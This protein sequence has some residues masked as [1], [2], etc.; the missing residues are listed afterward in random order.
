MKASTGRR[1]SALSVSLGKVLS[2]LASHTIGNRYNSCAKGK[3]PTPAF[4]FVSL[5][6]WHWL[7]ET[8]YTWCTCVEPFSA[9]W[10]LHTPTVPTPQ[11]PVV[12]RKT[13]TTPHASLSTRNMPYARGIAG[14]SL[15]FWSL[16]TNVPARWLGTPRSYQR[17]SHL[18]PLSP[19]Y[20][21]GPP[22]CW[23]A[24]ES[25]PSLP[26]TNATPLDPQT[27]RKPPIQQLAVRNK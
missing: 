22:H 20:L 8:V 17:N 3:D 13:T 4:C 6:M 25:R 14:T 23:G 26:R 12:G 15:P 11:P 10:S 16:P 1:K 2:P 18:V 19:P 7:C 27:Y 21:P 5:Q 9:F 24:G